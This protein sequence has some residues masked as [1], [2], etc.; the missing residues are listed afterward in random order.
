MYIYYFPQPQ[1]DFEPEAEGLLLLSAVDEDCSSLE[2]LDALKFLFDL[3]L[4][5]LHI[6]LLLKN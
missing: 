2:G 5:S 6:L 1:P 4:K 3:S